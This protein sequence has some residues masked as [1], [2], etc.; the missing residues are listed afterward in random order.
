MR[1]DSLSRLTRRITPA[2]SVTIGGTYVSWANPSTSFFPYFGQDA[3]GN[4]TGGTAQQAR[5]VTIPADT[6]TFGYDGMGN[7]LWANNRD[8]RISR[9]WNGNGTLASETQR[10]RSYAGTDTVTHA[11]RLDYR[12]DL[13]GR[14]TGLIHPANV[15]P[16][17]PARDSTGYAYDRVTGEL[18][19]V[20]GQATY[21]FAYDD[22]GR[23]QL[24][25]RGSTHETFAFDAGGRLSTRDDWSGNIRVHAD[26]TTYD[27]TTGEVTLV[28][29]TRE[30]VRQGRRGLGALAW[31]DTYDPLKG[32]RNVEYYGTDPLA[33][34]LSNTLEAYGT[35]QVAPSLTQNESVVHRYEPHTGRLL[36]TSQ[37]YSQGPYEVSMYDPAGN[38]YF[39]ASMASVPTPYT[40]NN[41]ANAPAPLRDESAMYYGADDRLHVADRRSCLYFPDSQTTYACDTTKAPTYE[42]RS[43][44]EEY[45]YDALGRRV[46]V[47]TRSEY[48]CPQFCLNTLR[49]TV[50][51]GDQVLY[52]ISAPG[53][54]TATAAQMEADTGLAV[55]FFLNAQHTAVAG[56]FPYGRVMYE[57]GGGLDAP[58]GVVRM[59]Y[60]SEL[61]DA[62]VIAPHATWRGTYDRGTPITGQCLVYSTNGKQL[63]PPPDSTPSSGDQYG[64]VVGGGTYGGTAEHCIEVD[65]PSAYTWSARQYRRG[66][67][68]A[69][70]WMGSLIF[71][72]RDA[73]G[74]YYRRNRYYDSEQGRFTQEDPIGLVGGV[75]Q[76]GFVG[77][78]PISYTDPYGLSP[79]SIK[80]STP[81]LE[82]K[83]RAAAAM[84]PT[85]AETLEDMDQD[86]H[87]LVHFGE[88][89]LDNP[90]V[91]GEPYLDRAGTTVIN[92]WFDFAEIRP[93]A[94]D[95]GVASNGG[96]AES[97]VIGHETYGHAQPRHEGWRCQDS[98]GCAR[99]RE[100]VIRREMH[101]RPRTF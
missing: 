40:W 49:R 31:V 69:S 39:R 10:I 47:R 34:Q 38:Q 90:G 17:A 82:R 92:V 18:V 36:S 64:G 84:S 83:V 88:K 29:S 11:Y 95:P 57:H 100:N 87:V 7:M 86:P 3:E 26:A 37:P 20:A 32:T 75:N 56:F 45:R 27:G 85:L 58:L 80:F 25:T 91:V 54:S 53:G 97:D 22:A 24:L 23:T 96:V 6:A 59:E 61:H 60:S 70:S 50:W 44:F 48:A 77:G 65:W 74:L 89:N 15:S 51:D 63:A 78:D 52:E 9:T 68:G 76:Y 30:W 41:N 5:T 98:T 72:S 94:A 16:H 28:T 14:R 43:A 67:N 2:A 66:Y 19:S 93:L 81:A 73:S 55:P 42:R 101:H 71:E 99:A 21:T 1:Y 33:N 35:T 12:Y 4:F 79:D 8:A 62:Q 46:L 13:E